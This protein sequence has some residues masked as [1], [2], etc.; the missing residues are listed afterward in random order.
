MLACVCLALWLTAA[1]VAL[2][3]EVAPD[4]GGELSQEE[5]AA[6]AARAAVYYYY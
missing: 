5:A 4:P 6:M 1:A 2:A 3:Q